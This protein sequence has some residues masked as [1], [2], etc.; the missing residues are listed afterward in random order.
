[1]TKKALAISIVIPVYNEEN[2]LKAC[3]QAVAA[4]T[5]PPFEVLV[6][7]NNST[8]KTVAIAKSF[9]F[10]TLLHEKRQGV[11]FARNKGFNAATGDII[12][13]IDADTLLQPNWV[14]RVQRDFR[15]DSLAA[16]T[17]P[18]SLY[19]MPFPDK[20]YRV[21]HF[22]RRRLFEYGKN[23]PF[24]FGTNMALRRTAWQAIAQEVCITG[25]D[26]HED[27][28]IAI[29]LDWR[30]AELLYD[31]QLLAGMSSRRYDDSLIDF[32]EYSR[33]MKR[34]YDK[35]GIE[36]LA[37]DIATSI[38]MVGYFVL[39]PLRRSYDETTKK[40]SLLT[41]L[42]GGNAARRNPMG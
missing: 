7:D 11:V 13:R 30:G 40:R 39:W 14:A 37:P 27:I 38:Y 12:G 23:F 21:D 41:L 42:Q 19:D 33:L 20:N 25:H 28:D 32:I 9:P 26:F 34:T 8:D 16:V 5:V 4:Q 36:S 17:G 2:H 24:L 6:V 31:E 10:V 18:V 29:H 22:F 35:H 3:L 1:M 15:R